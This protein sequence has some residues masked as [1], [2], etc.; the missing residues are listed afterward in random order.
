MKA[1]NSQKDSSLH[2]VPLRM[3]IAEVFM[4]MKDGSGSTA[5]ILH[6]PF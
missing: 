2:F 1:A 5:S 6:R 4:A 3:T